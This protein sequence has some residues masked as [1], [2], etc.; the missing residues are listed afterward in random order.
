MGVIQLERKI[1]YRA[2]DILTACDNEL[3]VPDGLLGHSAIAINGTYMIEAVINKPHIQIARISK[4]QRNHPKHAVYRPKKKVW[5]EGA[6]AFAKAYLARRNY[7]KRRGR[8]K[9][10]FSFSPQKPL[11]DP[12]VSVYCSKLVWLCYHYGSDYTLRNDGFLFSPEDLDSLLRK[13]RNFST[14]YRHPN[15]KFLIDT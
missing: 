11:S 10:P 2:G 7:Y 15:F 14:L 8:E 12:F 5:G 9:P 13:D 1:Q 6:A 3:Q 4:F